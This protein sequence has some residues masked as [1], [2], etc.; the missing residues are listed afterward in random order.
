MPTQQL[1]LLAAPLRML[2]HGGLLYHFSVAGVDVHNM[3]GQRVAWAE[4]SG[5]TCGAV[6]TDAVYLG[7]S[8]GV[9]SL[10]HSAVATGG[11]QT[12]AVALAYDTG[13]SPALADDAVA[14]LAGL[15]TTLLVT[16]AA[17]ADYLPNAS[18]VYRYSDASGC[19]P[20]ALSATELA[21]ILGDGTVHRLVLPTTDWTSSSATI[22]SA[23]GETTPPALNKLTDPTAPPG[24]GYAVAWSGDYLAVGHASGNLLSI[25]K[26]SGSTLSKLA[27]P[28]SPGSAVFG[29]AWSG[30]YLAVGKSASPY[31]SWYSRSGDTLT[32]LTDPTTPPG[33]TYRLAWSGDYLVVPHAVG[34]GTRGLSFYKR[35]G[36]TLSKLTDPA[37]PGGGGNTAAWI[38]SYL[39]VG[40]TGSPY[41]VVYR[42]DGDTLTKLSAVADAPAGAV[43]WLAVS[44]DYL[45]VTCAASPYLYLYQWDAA[46]ETLTQKAGPASA[47]PGAG[48]G[49][50]WSGDY[51]MVGFNASPWLSVYKRAG[52]ALEKELDADSLSAAAYSCGVDSNRLAVSMTASPYLYWYELVPGTTGGDGLLAAADCIAFGADLFVGSA[53]GI[54]IIGATSRE[55][56]ALLGGAPVAAIHPTSTATTSAGLLAYGT[57]DGADGGRFGIIDLSA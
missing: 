52:G 32:K 7:T 36:S 15:G 24:S 25:Y 23:S 5:V 2:F 38:G 33:A 46:T 27:D 18:T 55:L 49:L 35:S 13:T 42:R 14:G 47:L 43:S 16:H 19:G 34:A 8:A 22:Y 17:G 56:T 39:F 4:L 1:T 44:G 26:K 40:T 48:R 12:S 28:A 57:D 53:G 54:N 11:D 10:A 51:L 9:Y 45:A 29:V 20:C 21:Y 31:L 41:L 30:D 37:D 3:L 50:A 6:N